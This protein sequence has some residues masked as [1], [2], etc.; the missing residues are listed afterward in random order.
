MDDAVYLVLFE[1]F[2][3]SVNVTTINIIEL[4]SLACDL[5]Q[6]VL[7]FHLTVGKIVSDNYIITVLMKRDNGM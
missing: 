6:A 4:K 7:D 2:S 1:N 3:K 5:L